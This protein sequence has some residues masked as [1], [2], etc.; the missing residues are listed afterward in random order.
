MN[1]VISDGGDGSDKADEDGR[2]LRE[3]LRDGGHRGLLEE[4][5]LA[6]TQGGGGAG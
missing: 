2:D 1:K 6:Q 4:V 3:V 5:T